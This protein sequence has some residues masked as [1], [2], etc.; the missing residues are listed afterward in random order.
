MIMNFI[1]ALTGQPLL[2][3]PY[4]VAALTAIGY[5]LFFAIPDF[6]NNLTPKKV[7]GARVATKN[8]A[9]IRIQY[10]GG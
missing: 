7:R 8:V 2:S 1:T 9:T 6:L 3:H 4:N 10:C 5:I